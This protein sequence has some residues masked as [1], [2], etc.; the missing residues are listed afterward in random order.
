MKYKVAAEVGGQEEREAYAL[1][2]KTR[3]EEIGEFK[4]RLWAQKVVDDPIFARMRIEKW[5][6]YPP[7]VST[8][9]LYII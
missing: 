7:H 5:R 8:Y 4:Y 3:I 1:Y 9:D 6:S 2:E